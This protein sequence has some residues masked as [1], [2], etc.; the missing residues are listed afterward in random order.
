MVQ[1]IIFRYL[2][3]LVICLTLLHNPIV[4]NTHELKCESSFKVL[5]KQYVWL[6]LSFYNKIHYKSLKHKLDPALVCSL[7]HSESYDRKYRHTLKKMQAAISVAGARS[8]MQVMPVHYKG[9][10]KD[11][12]NVDLNFRLGMRY[13]RRCILVSK[14]NLHE[15]LRKYNQGINGNRSRYAGWISYVRVI[16][17]RYKYYLKYT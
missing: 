3:F 16:L 6:T 17:R 10:P 15:A 1:D 11:L 5:K 2:K 12:H 8:F 9:N 7:I 13:L 14:G 4:T